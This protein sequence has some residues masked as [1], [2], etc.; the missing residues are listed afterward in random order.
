[1]GST[2]ILASAVAVPLPSSVRGTITVSIDVEDWH[3]L[4]TRRWSGQLPEC[5]HHVE[6]Q[7]DRVLDIMDAHGVKG[8]FFVLGLVARAKPALVRKLAD[9]GHEIGSHGTQHVPLHLLERRD[10]ARELRESR[11]LLADITGA[12]VVG[13]RAPEFSITEKNLWVL[14]EIAAA[15]YRYDSSIYPIVH[16]R[17]GVSTFARGPVKLTL[18]TGPLWE[19]PLA[20]LPLATKN[21]PIAGGGYFRLFPGIALEQALR[22][23]TRRG[24][25]V[26][27]YFHP[28]EFSSTPLTLAADVLPTSPVGRAKAAAW[29][30][31]QRLGRTRLPARAE[32][33]A[34]VARAIRCL[35]LVDA[36]EV[37]DR[38]KQDGSH[39]IS[40]AS[41]VVS[42]SPSR[43]IADV[44]N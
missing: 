37:L 7:V 24:E 2:D 34:K 5:S 1:M 15:G 16:P 10:V 43:S 4:V 35:D 32:R 20:T 41:E 17:Y 6:S 18:E 38:T 23:L 33:A 25:H 8:T 27:L 13:F 31:L 12:P 29:F 9:R 21:V 39:A 26:M 28:Y 30:V 14:E 44:R 42:P 22:S 19:L 40:P 3:Q 36:L 11:E